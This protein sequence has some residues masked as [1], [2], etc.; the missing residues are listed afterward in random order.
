MSD[1]GYFDPQRGLY[2]GW[3]TMLSS[4][5]FYDRDETLYQAP[6]GT[7]TTI[8]AYNQRLFDEAGVAQPSADWTWEGE[9]LEAAKKLSEPENQWGVNGSTAVASA[10]PARC[11]RRWAAHSSTPKP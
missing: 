6:L 4:D 9:F 8:P 3:F 10:S 2:P 5:G 7:G 1:L 11:R